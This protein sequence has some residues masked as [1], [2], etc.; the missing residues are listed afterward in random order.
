MKTSRS[1]M[2]KVDSKDPEIT[3][4]AGKGLKR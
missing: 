3:L 4:K 2:H 1:N